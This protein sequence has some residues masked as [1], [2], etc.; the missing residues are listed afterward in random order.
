[1]ENLNELMKNIALAEMEYGKAM[2]RAVKPFKEELTKLKEKSD[3]HP[4]SH[5]AAILDSSINHSWTRILDG[6]EMVSNTHIEIADTFANERKTIKLQSK[7]IETYFADKFKA[8][9]AQ[10]KIMQDKIAFLE[11][12]GGNYEREIRDVDSASSTLRKHSKDPS[13]SR[14]KIDK[15]KIDYEKKAIAT[16]SANAAYRAALL[17][18]NN[19]KNNFY[20]NT[21]VSELDVNILLII[22][23]TI[24]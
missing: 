6:V 5:Y 12:A 15:T 1:M 20:T 9:R 18:L 10:E 7:E 4:K 14:D 8:I 17:D 2:Q 13:M 19:F 23:H 3:K 24:I 22:E 21:L 11:K 16:S